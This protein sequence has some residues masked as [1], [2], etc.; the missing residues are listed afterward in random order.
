MAIKVLLFGQLT[1][2]TN[3]SELVLNS[4]NDTNQLQTF[5]NEKYPLF[6]NMNYAIAINKK[7]TDQKSSLKEGDT[8][9]LLP[10]FSGG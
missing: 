5:L 3:E 10:A 2:I 7:I 4:I 6:K 8:V 9:A 1:E